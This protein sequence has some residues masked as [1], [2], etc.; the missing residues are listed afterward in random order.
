MLQ[1]KVWLLERTLAQWNTQ[2]YLQRRCKILSV[3]THLILIIREEQFENYVLLSNNLLQTALKNIR[4]TT[5]STIGLFRFGVW[6]AWKGFL[7]KMESPSI[8]KCFC[9]VWIPKR[10]N[11]FVTVFNYYCKFFLEVLKN[12]CSPINSCMF[13]LFRNLFKLWRAVWVVPG[14]KS[15]KRSP[16]PRLQVSTFCVIKKLL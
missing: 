9:G 4:L 5:N 8:E 12:N 1:R 15:E 6:R 11:D 13:Y 2:Q 14:R 16:E 3:S 7:A 10:E